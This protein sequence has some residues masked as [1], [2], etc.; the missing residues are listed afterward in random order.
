MS[1]IGEI[2]KRH[3]SDKGGPHG[4]GP[5]YD[6]LFPPARRGLAR[7]VLEIGVDYGHSLTG[8]AEVFPNAQV[9]G[10]DVRPPPWWPRA[11]PPRVEVHQVDQRDAAGLARAAAGLAGPHHT[12]GEVRP[13]AMPA[14]DL[15]V[16]D[17]SHAL[18]DQLL[19]LPVLLPWLAPGGAYVVEE[20]DWC[21]RPPG[22]G[23]RLVP[24]G[25]PPRPDAF[26]AIPG[27]EVIWTTAESGLREPL[28]VIRG[29]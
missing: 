20:P 28:V 26:R 18:D 13:R 11:C 25:E 3:G 8:W 21:E 15:I 14:F 4:Y 29:R 24:R 9:V 2:M 16:D 17:G 7:A 27:A 12:Y 23:G 22:V 1:D 6:A 10:V 5:V 19:S